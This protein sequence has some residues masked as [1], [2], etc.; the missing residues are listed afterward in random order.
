MVFFL[1]HVFF[2]LLWGD[3]FHSK[4]D[5]R[6][7][8]NKR[9]LALSICLPHHVNFPSTGIHLTISCFKSLKYVF[10]ILFTEFY[11]LEQKSVMEI[12]PPIYI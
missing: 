10:F 5:H 6:F 1:L 11:A 12:K 4:Y 8:I 2:K 3:V 9:D 7:Y